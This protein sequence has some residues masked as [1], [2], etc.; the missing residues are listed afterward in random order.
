MKVIA[1]SRIH[2]CLIDMGHVSARA[3]CG[4]GFALA[5]PNTALNIELS[6]Q[7][8]LIGFERYK[9]EI[10]SEIFT[11][12]NKLKTNY[13]VP[14]VKIT[15]LSAPPEHVGYGT[16]TA[17]F[18]SVIT[19]INAHFNLNLSTDDLQEISGRGGASGIGVHTFFQGGFIWDGGHP[20]TQDKSLLPSRA[21]K[22]SG[23]PPML[24]RLTFPNDWRIALILPKD[25]CIEGD[26]EQTF[27]TQN[28]PIPR[29]EILEVMRIAYHGIIPAIATHDLQLLSAAISDIHK[30]GFKSRELTL[31]SQPVRDLLNALHTLGISAGMSSF[32]PLIYAIVHQNDVKAI[33]AIQDLSASFRIP[34][35]RFV[36]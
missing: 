5:E 29:D 1:H 16:K 10:K 26:A 13:G 4:L 14:S 24:A 19:G 36:T 6:E 17:L 22:G 25:A 8:T 20:P 15:L 33:N 34:D 11:F 2:I 9:I 3:Y 23:F 12:L 21:R 32:G 7:N 35:P 30:I 18:L 31:R 27:F 28:T